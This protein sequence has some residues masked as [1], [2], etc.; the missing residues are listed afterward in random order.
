MFR[1]LSLAAIAALS[2]SVCAQ[3]V[4]TI[5]QGFGSTEAKYSRHVPLR[6]TPARIQFGYGPKAT[7]WTAPKVITELW[8]RADG[9]KHLTTAFTIDSE[10][11]LSSN[12]CDPETTSYTF[13]A[14]HGKDVRVFMKRK[15]MSFQ[16][17]TAAPSPAPFS[18][19]LKGD[20]PFVAIQPTLLVD[21]KTYSK[22]NE[23][24]DN[25]Y[26]DA[27]DVTGT[28]SGT[29][30]TVS[31]TGT[32]CNPTDF[33]SYATGYNVGESFRPYCYTRNVGDFV[34]H[35]L[36]GTPVSIAIPG[37]PG[38]TLYTNPIAF[39]PVIQKTTNTSA[40]YFEWGKVPAAMKGAPVIC[41]F[42]A[43]D[44]TFKNFR[45]SR[46]ANVVFGD[47]KMNYPY[48]ISHRYAYGSG[49]NSF[50]PDKDPAVYGW[51]D[52]AVIFEVK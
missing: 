17:F 29:R 22:T 43:V 25:F 39:H 28:A 15:T 11:S 49:T 19:Q 35:W 20:A 38:C 44:A 37:M 3:T 21:W 7:G 18:V 52:T 48:M 30:G 13:A 31:Y 5:P 9:G 4:T 41:Q 26:L 32:S 51:I 33:Y 47:Y 16:P 50:D 40:L 34:L 10:V 36:G 45:W 27:D 1:H 46:A 14:N 24:H 2:A 12:G 6:Y 8:A 42:A 23:V